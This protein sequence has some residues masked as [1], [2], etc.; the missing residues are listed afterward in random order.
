MAEKTFT[1]TCTMEERWVNH[2]L[3]A[4]KRMEL[5]GRIGASDD[6]AIYADGDGDFR[7]KFEANIEYEVQEPYSERNGVIRYDAG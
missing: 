1:V 2:F 4:L 7:P 6:V 5:N 3:S